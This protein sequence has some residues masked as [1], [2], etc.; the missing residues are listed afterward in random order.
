MARFNNDGVID[1]IEI[2]SGSVLSN[3]AKRNYPSFNI[4]SVNNRTSVESFLS[5]LD[6]EDFND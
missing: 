2:G 5:Y 6:N 4:R 3:L 1:Y